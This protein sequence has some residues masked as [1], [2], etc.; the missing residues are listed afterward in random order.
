M[1]VFGGVEK[2]DVRFQKRFVTALQSLNQKTWLYVREL[3][4]GG[5]VGVLWMRDLA[6]ALEMGDS[7]MVVA[8]VL[9]SASASSLLGILSG[10]CT[11]RKAVG[12]YRALICD[13]KW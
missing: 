11:P 2:I 5:T 9:A 3:A 4:C 8:T 6:Y 13:H 10:P 12:P 1:W 7:L